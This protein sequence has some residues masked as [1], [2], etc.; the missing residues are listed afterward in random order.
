MPVKVVFDTNILCS[1]TGW[2]GH[3]FQCVELGRAGKVQ[4][5]S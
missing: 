2:R 4:A 1:A 3:P 5:V